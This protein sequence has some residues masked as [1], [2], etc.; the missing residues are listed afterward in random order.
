MAPA[1]KINIALKNKSEKFLWGV[2]FDSS[3]VQP[4]RCWPSIHSKSSNLRQ[5]TDG[6]S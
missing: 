4:M 6:C 1:L 3:D 2:E 5:L